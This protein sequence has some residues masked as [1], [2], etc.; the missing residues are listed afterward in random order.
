MGE[1]DGRYWQQFLLPGEQLIHTFGVSRLYLAVFWWL[2]LLGALAGAAAAAA[3]AE[4]AISLLL[5][6]MAIGLALPP[7]YLAFFVRYAITG[8]RVMSREGVLHKE[9][10]TV[11]LPAITDITIR[12]S[13]LE[14]LFTRS[15]AVY[16]NTAGSDQIELPLRHVS[17]PFDRRRDIY[18]HQQQAA[19]ERLPGAVTAG[20]EEHRH[21]ESQGGAG[22]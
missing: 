14:R 7:L 22:V 21:A 19:P 9:F 11:D 13:F 4:P 3:L 1:I 16:I 15:G 8:R 5:L 12:E 6:I 10:I 20:G 18:R 2:P 17:R